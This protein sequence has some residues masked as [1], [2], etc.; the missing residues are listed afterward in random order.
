MVPPG[1]LEPIETV[2]DRYVSVVTYTSTVGCEALVAG[3]QVRA[4][5]G[6]NLTCG[7]TDEYRDEWHHTLSWRQSTH[8]TFGELVP[9]ILSGY[10]DARQRARLGVVEHPRERIRDKRQEEEYYKI[11][12]GSY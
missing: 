2:L 11:I 4:D 8:D 6:A 5:H 1:S 3:C 9:Y 10:D 12:K 7:V